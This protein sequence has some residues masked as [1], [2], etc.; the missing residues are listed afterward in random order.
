MELS[1]AD[2]L[3]HLLKAEIVLLR[4]WYHESVQKQKG[5][6]L[7]G[8]TALSPEEIVDYLVG[9][10]DDPHIPSFVEGESMPRAI[11]LSADDLK[12]FYYQ[13]AMARPAGVTGIALDNW[14]FGETRA[15]EL[16]FELRRLLLSM[17]DP[18]LRRVGEI[19]LVPHT[20]L[21]HLR[22]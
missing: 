5:R 21:H 14:F 4:P 10:L 2:Q 3:R 18:A 20:M 8:L 16:H 6:R 7:N 19:S 9:Y 12:H 11:K 17:E 22:D 1:D 15:G 13:A